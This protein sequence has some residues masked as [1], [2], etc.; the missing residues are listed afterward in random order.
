MSTSNQEAKSEVAEIL[1]RAQFL[2]AGNDEDLQAW[3]HRVDPQLGDITPQ[4]AL[5]AG[6]VKAVSFIIEEALRGDPD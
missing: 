5:D 3:L 1:Q 4:Q 6:Q 2:F